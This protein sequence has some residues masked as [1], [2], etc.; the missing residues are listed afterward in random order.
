MSGFMNI[1]GINYFF[2][3]SSACIVQDGRLV[4]ALEE[5]RFTRR[6]HTYEFPR[7]SASRC[8]ELAGL[9]AADITHIAVSIKPSLHWP[10]KT[11]YALRHLG[12]AKPF[13]KHELLG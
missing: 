3:D 10:R 7:I 9:K 5:E 8:L 11:L 13:F 1:L 4:C 2:H 12:N 6:K